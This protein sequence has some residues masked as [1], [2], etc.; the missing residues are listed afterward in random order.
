LACSPYSHAAAAA[1]RLAA[2]SVV[3]SLIHQSSNQG[4]IEHE[5]RRPA[6]QQRPLIISTLLADRLA[7]HGGK[8][9]SHPT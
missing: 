3:T 6:T 1:G 7:E 8:P 9:A 5:V 2:L 4:R